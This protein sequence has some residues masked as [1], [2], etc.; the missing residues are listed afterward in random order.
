[1][2]KDGLPTMKELGEGECAYA[3]VLRRADIPPSTQKK[4]LRKI[5]IQKKFADLLI[6]FMERNS[7]SSI[8]ELA[9][10][11]YIGED[12]VEILEWLRDPFLKMTE[13]EILEYLRSLSVDD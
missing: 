6:L 7:I 2:P 1:M 8:Q 3:R 11:L 9:N 12:H 4:V 13:N 5:H 10:L